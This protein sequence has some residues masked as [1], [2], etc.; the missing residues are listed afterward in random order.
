[1]SLTRQNPARRHVA[2]YDVSLRDGQHAVG[3]KLTAEQL[4]GYASRVD[5]VGLSVVEVG[6]GNGLAASS[7]LVG[8]AAVSDRERYDV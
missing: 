2:L 8:Q 6:H 7:L 5:D 4:F 1:M 3:H